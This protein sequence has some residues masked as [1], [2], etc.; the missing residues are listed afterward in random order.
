MAGIIPA[1]AG[2]TLSNLKYWRTDG[3]HPRMCGEH[4]SCVSI[5][6]MSP[7]S[8]PHVRGAQ[9]NPSRP[10]KRP[11]I[12]P[13][14]AGSTTAPHMRERMCWDHPRM[15]GEHCS[16]RCLLFARAG[17]SPHVRG[18]PVNY[19]TGGASAGIIPAC[20]GSTANWT[21]LSCPQRDHPRMCGE[22]FADGTC[23]EP[24][25]G[26]SPHVRG[27]RHPAP[28]AVRGVG[29]IPACAGSTIWVWRCCAVC[30]DHPRMCGEHLR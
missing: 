16:L 24:F 4:F 1:C 15:C 12:I 21:R 18:A 25:Q 17:S 5:F 9:A 30:R 14:C 20:A 22:H 26:S 6:T 19:N 23:V 29:I 28:A 27:A 2:S 10:A 7:G 13:A 8:S 3:D 11:G